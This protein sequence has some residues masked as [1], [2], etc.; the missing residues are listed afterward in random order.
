[1]RPFIQWAKSFPETDYAQWL[2]DA[3]SSGGANRRF[4]K[5]AEFAGAFLHQPQYGRGTT[6]FILCRLEESFD[7][8]E[9]VNLSTATIEHVLPQTLNQAWKDDLGAQSDEIHS[10]LLNTFGNLTLTGY[11]PELGNLPF[12]DKKIQL[13]NTHIELSR[14]ILSQDRW[15]AEEI[16]A[17]AQQLLDRAIQ[18]WPSP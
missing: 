6:R 17:R 2:H 15:G 11:N 4:P 18:L 7:H 3:L 16:E 1:M 12:S 10:S 9:V 13:K 14:W 5:D 8:K